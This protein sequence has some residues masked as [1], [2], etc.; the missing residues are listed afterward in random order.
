[1]AKWSVV[2][3]S[4]NEGNRIATSDDPT[5]IIVDNLGHEPVTPT[6]TPCGYWPGQIVT[7]KE[8]SYIVALFN[9]S[10]QLVGRVDYNTGVIDPASGYIIGTY[11]APGLFPFVYKEKLYISATNQ[12]GWLS[13]FEYDLE[14]KITTR[15][16]PVMRGSLHG[17]LLYK[18]GNMVYVI[19]ESDNY[20]GPD[21]RERI[22]EVDLDAFVITG[23]MIGLSGSYGPCKN[24]TIYG[25][26]MFFVTGTD[27]IVLNLKSFTF[28][29]SLSYA[30][31][32]SGAICA[33]FN[34]EKTEC[35]IARNNYT[36]GLQK[37]SLTNPPT[38]LA[39]KNTDWLADN[40]KGITR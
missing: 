32:G 26:L 38:V 17:S 7:P 6:H 8:Y 33:V 12:D 11:S 21:Y 1:M 14:A 30:S 20:G 22:H 15:V 37:I 40:E 34:N 29:N 24:F 35:I 19:G 13:L 39:T 16:L 10:P 31:S 5:W 27:V 9:N 4:Y 18:A 23:R 3:N 2:K 25:S 28:L 36:P